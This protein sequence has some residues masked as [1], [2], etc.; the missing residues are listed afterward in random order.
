MGAQKPLEVKIF[1]TLQL[2][3]G[4]SLLSYEGPPL[5]V[6]AL[7]DWIQARADAAGKNVDVRHELLAEDQSIRP[8]TMI[9]IDGRNIHHLQGIHTLVAGGT[10]SVFPPAGGG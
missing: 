4:M 3:L 10:V 1:A 6:D 5:T 9:L 2:K 7:I 8:G